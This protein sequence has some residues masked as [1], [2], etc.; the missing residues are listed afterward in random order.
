VAP[1]EITNES[2]GIF[3]SWPCSLAIAL[4]D[5][6]ATGV[7]LLIRARVCLAVLAVACASAGAHPEPDVEATLTRGGGLAAITEM[8][9]VSR[10]GPQVTATF[11]SSASRRQRTVRLPSATLVATLADLDSLV[12]AVPPAVPDSGP[13]Q[14]LCGDAA[15]TRLTVRHGQEV[16]A[17]QEACPHFGVALDAYWRRVNG[18][19]DL[20]AN[21]AP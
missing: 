13:M 1:V 11:R 9:R 20:L 3:P 16:R 2:L 10:V 4:A 5:T 12:G 21:A 15:T 8:V 14:R 17:A 6:Q 19:F 18:V 7:M